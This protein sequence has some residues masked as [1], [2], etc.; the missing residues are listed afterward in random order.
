MSG[1]KLN[2]CFLSSP[3][4]YGLDIRSRLCWSIPL[5]QNFS[6]KASDVMKQGL[7]RIHS[8]CGC[9]RQ[10]AMCSQPCL[11]L[12]DPV[13][14]SPPGSSVHEILPAR[15]LEWGALSFSRESSRPRDWTCV[16]YISCIGR[17]IYYQ[18]HIGSPRYWPI[19]FLILSDFGIRWWWPP[20]TI[21]GI[22]LLPPV[23]RVWEESV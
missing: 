5:V 17:E 11:T 2:I 22:F 10:C 8:G 9:Q 13:D 20:I 18:Y 15:I 14:C 23:G 21:L 19:I 6:L 4:S 12:C 16:S 3:L 7:C 1:K